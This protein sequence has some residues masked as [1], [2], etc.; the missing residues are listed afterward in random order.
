MV[1][2]RFRIG[3]IVDVMVYW[4]QRRVRLQVFFMLW[5]VF[6]LGLGSVV[7]PIIQC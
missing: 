4:A 1:K 5:L 2:L 3:I 7:I 6:E